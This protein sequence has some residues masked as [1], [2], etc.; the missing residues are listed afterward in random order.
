M[1]G[2]FLRGE[3]YWVC[4]DDSIGNE[5]K[6]GRPGVIISA[7]GLNE[8]EGRVTI[9]FLSTAG[10]SSANRPSIIAPK[11][12]RQR[13]LCD[14]LRTVDVSRLNKYMFTCTESEMTR[15]TGALACT[16]CIPTP[17]QEK[18]APTD[19]S[20]VE[21]MRAEIDMWRKMYEKTMDQLVEL[22]VATV[23]AQRTNRVVAVETAAE[24]ELIVDDIVPEEVPVVKHGLVEPDP[25]FEE[26]PKKRKKNDIVWDGVKVNINTVKTGKELHQ[27]IGIATRTAEEIVR[28]RKTVGNYSSVDDLLALDNFGQRCMKR[29]GHMLEV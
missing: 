16:L 26:E 19:D 22:R 17:K 12:D 29:Y 27:K 18:K 11:G 21:S 23:V 13:V 9:A 10:F 3:V 8:K 6:T 4:L 20:V 2:E 25:G 28:V 7:N 5:E 24:K 14:Q 15:I 1:N